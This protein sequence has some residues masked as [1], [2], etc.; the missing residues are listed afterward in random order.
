M[1]I[2]R[3]QHQEE[4]ALLTG[5]IEWAPGHDRPG[6]V[7]FDGRGRQCGVFPAKKV[8][9]RRQR[10]D[11][12]LHTSQGEVLALIRDVATEVDGR[13]WGAY[14]LTQTIDGAPVAPPIPWSA[15]KRGPLA[16]EPP[17]PLEIPGQA[18]L[19]LEVD[20]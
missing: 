9:G 10:W 13:A 14:L 20:K 5:A 16:A 17:A 3:R 6:I 8:D 11:V 2:T 15:E 7:A 18:E 4:R 1:A 12:M 19:P